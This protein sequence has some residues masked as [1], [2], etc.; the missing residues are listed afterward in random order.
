MDKRTLLETRQIRLENGEI[1]PIKV[2]LKKSGN[3]LSARVCYGQLELYVFKSTTERQIEEFV[4]KVGKVFKGRNMNNPFYK[5]DVYIY[6]LGEKYLITKD[7]KYK[8]REGYFYVP[9]NCKDPITIYKKHFLEYLKKRVVEIGVRMNVDLSDWKIRT[10]L[11]LSY[12]G[13][14]F[15]TKHQFKFDYRLFA[16]RK[17]IL[18]A[19][20]YHEVTHTYELS[21]N[22]RFYK[23]LKC[24][25]PLY[26]NL[27]EDITLGYFEG[28]ENCCVI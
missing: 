3:R 20:I 17:D 27:M 11:F 16:Y 21:H 5:E 18:D 10:G 6:V 14:C 23:I 24:Y 25:C 9:T 4:T 8:N 1:I 28:R 26:D 19:V 15:T 22:Q 13:I 12:Y 7:I 2:Y